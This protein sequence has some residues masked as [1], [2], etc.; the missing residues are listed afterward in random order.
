MEHAVKITFVQ[1]VFLSA[2]A[3]LAFSAQSAAAQN[4]SPSA[5]LGGYGAKFIDV[6]GVKTRHYDPRPRGATPPAQ[7]GAGKKRPASG[8]AGRPGDTFHPPGRGKAA[9]PPRRRG[10][11][12]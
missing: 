6:A 10:G 7:A 5:S 12:D 8:V 11:A 2:A 4:V 9:H 1:M 3:A